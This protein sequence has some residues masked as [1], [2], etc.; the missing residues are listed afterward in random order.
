MSIK[1]SLYL[2]HIAKT[3]PGRSFIEV[4]RTEGVFV[5]DADDKKYY[6]LASGIGPS[7]LGHHHPAIQEAIDRQSRSYLH[8]MVYGMHIQSPQVDLAVQLLDHL[9]D[10]FEQVYFLSSGSEAIEAA[11]KMA[12]LFTGRKKVVAAHNAY[13]G[14]TVGAESLRSDVDFIQNLA[15]LVPGVEHLR[16]N[17]L[18]DLDRIDSGTACVIMEPVQAEAGIVVPDREYMQALRAKCDTCG[19][20]LIFDEIQMGMGRTGT[21]FAFEAFGIRPDILVLGKAIGGGLPLSAVVTSKEIAQSISH[22]F[23]LS[24]LTTFGGHPLC[25]ATGL[26]ALRVITEGKMWE[27]ARE[28]GTLYRDLLEPHF[29]HFRQYGAMFGM[30]VGG[31]EQAAAFQRLLQE[32]GVISDILL[33]NSG[34]VRMAPPLVIS[35]DEIQDSAQRILRAGKRL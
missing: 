12:K 6:D 34:M 30:E 17:H 26:A 31:Y 28:I 22:R 16:F 14:S 4:Q 8:T 11:L 3:D 20:L 18:E 29:D 21:L 24:H 32:E 19:T 27:R 9:P 15:P 10:F 13:H 7:I 33:F 1:R 23:P 2:N 5:I 25:C 35:N